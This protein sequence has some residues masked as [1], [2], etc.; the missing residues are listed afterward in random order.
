MGGMRI[1]LGQK[2]VYLA[3]CWR[4]LTVDIAASKK[5]SADFTCAGVWLIT[6][7]GD[8][9]LIDGDS[10]RLEEVD[11]WGLVSP[12]RERWAADTVFIESRM[13]GTTLVV[14]LT[15]HGVPTSELKAEVDKITRAIPASARLDQGRAWFPAGDTASLQVRD[16]VDQLVQF[17]NAV[18]DDW[19]DVFSYA[20]RVAIAH[21]TGNPLARKVI[22]G[23]ITDIDRAYQ[24]Q[25]G[26]DPELPAPN[27]MQLP[28][29]S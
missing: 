19:V 4:F 18:H 15:K 6:L 23:Q 26:N 2:I 3:E 9:V 29:G 1:M 8:L 16:V 25:T 5:T 20:A 28:Y 21:W 11:H 17:P 22:R 14:E 10:G 12:L 27:L 7:E 24:S 13:F